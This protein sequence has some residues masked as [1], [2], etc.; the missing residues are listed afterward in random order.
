MK[1]PLSAALLVGVD[2]PCTVVANTLWVAG[3]LVRAPF[4]LLFQPSVEPTEIKV[5]QINT[6]SAS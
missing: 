4:V 3:E 2:V 1:W 6:A 5:N